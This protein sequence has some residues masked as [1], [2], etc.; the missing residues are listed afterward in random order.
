MSRKIKSKRW[1]SVKKNLLSCQLEKFSEESNTLAQIGSHKNLCGHPELNLIESPE[2]D[3][4]IGSDLAKMMSPEN[5]VNQFILERKWKQETWFSPHMSNIFF[6]F[7]NDVLVVKHVLYLYITHTCGFWIF[8][9][10]SREI[11]DNTSFWKQASFFF[12]ANVHMTF[13]WVRNEFLSLFCMWASEQPVWMFNV[14][15]M[16]VLFSRVLLLL[17]LK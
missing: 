11:L 4:Q 8:V 2:E 12:P 14:V 10:E 17:F 13:K 7:S 9:K 1:K 16:S 5:A 15:V 6:I 3:V